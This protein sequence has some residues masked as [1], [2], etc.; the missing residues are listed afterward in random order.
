MN[1]TVKQYN[2]KGEPSPAAGADIAWSEAGTTTESQ[3]HATLKFSAT[4]PYELK[5]AGSESGPPAVRTET[6]ICVHN[7]ND[8]TC[9]TKGPAGST[10][11]ATSSS[12]GG[13]SSGGLASFATR[14]TGPYALVAAATGLIDGH[15]YSHGRAPRILSGSILAHNA[16]TS[17][18]LELRRVYKG[19]CYAYDGRIERFRSARCGHGSFFKAS[20]NGTFSYLLPA[21][22][23]PG[24]Y[25]LDIEATDAAGNHTS[26]ARGTSRIV[27]YVR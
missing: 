13:T 26:L 4:G 27:F 22:L 10:G 17:L 12:S 5:V 19:R 14:Y 25:V 16:V 7:G 1:V 24:R 11:S 20:A 9:G 2:A 3:G 6:T 15:V 8:G 18:S 23:A 21:P